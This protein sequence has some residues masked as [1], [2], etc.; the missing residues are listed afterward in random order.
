MPVNSEQT[1]LQLVIL[2]DL[3]ERRWL[4]LNGRGMDAVIIAAATE[5]V[6]L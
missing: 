5:A 3:E 4:F 6:S 2:N 1:L